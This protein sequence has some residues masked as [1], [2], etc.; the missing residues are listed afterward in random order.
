M[1]RFCGELARVVD[2]ALGGIG[3]GHADAGDVFL[4]YRGDGDG[5]DDG[6][7]D[8]AAQA[9]QDLAKSALADVVAGAADRAPAAAAEISSAGCGRMSPF[10]GDRIEQDQIF[11]EGSG[12]RGDLAVGSKAKLPPSKT[13][14]SLP[15]T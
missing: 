2:A 6:G 4:P 8:A 3:A 12:V 5:G 11:L 15:P 10:A 14:V 9:D 7:V 13:R 1:P